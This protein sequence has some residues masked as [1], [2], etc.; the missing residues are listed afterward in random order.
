MILFTRYISGHRLRDERLY[1]GKTQKQMA[2]WMGVSRGTYASWE[3]RY[4]NRNLPENVRKKLFCIVTGW[5]NQ[6]FLYHHMQEFEEIFEEKESIW[7]RI[8]K[9]IMHKN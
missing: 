6:K 8:Y 1:W 3:S 5:E 7:K 9:W 4:K 2:V